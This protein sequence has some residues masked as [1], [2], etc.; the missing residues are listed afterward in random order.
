MAV[1]GTSA[2]AKSARVGTG[3]FQFQAQ[4]GWEQLPA[5]WNLVEVAGVATDSSGN[6]LVFNRGEHPLIVFDRQG[7]FLRSWGEGV[8][9]RPHGLTIGPD[10]AVYCV[11]DAGHAV[12]KFSPEGEL[13]L[14]LGVPGVA[15]DTG[16]QGFDYRTIR[17]AAGPFNCPTN[18]A[19]A[20][21]GDMYVADGYGNARVH[22]FAADGQLIRS[23]GRCGAGP[24][25]FHVPHGIAV[26]RAGTVYVADRENSR[27]QLFS[28]DGRFVDQW[29]GIARPCQVRFDAVGNLYVAE[30]GYR[31]GMFPGN[32]PPPESTAEGAGPTGGRLSIFGAGGQLLTRI[33]GGERPTAAGDFLAPHD[34]WIDRFG[35]VYTA[36]VIASAGCPGRPSP[37]ECHTLQKFIRVTT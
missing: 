5:G 3:E 8:F 9:V 6:V 36:E 27:I 2:Q 18:L 30:L 22:H 31:A 14:S 21:N 12:H 19:L 24:G 13:V 16:A 32:V 23:W 17:R 25:E 34:V 29:T 35:D 15:A 11:D 28:P 7:R 10:D 26:D 20:A 4:V 1:G 37:G 33:G